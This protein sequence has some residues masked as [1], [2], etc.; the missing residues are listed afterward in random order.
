MPVPLAITESL[1][2]PSGPAVVQWRRNPRA[3]RITLRIDPRAGHVVVTLPMRA[4]RAAGMALLTQNAD[5]VS[6]R[7]AAL[8]VIVPFAPGGTVTIDGVAHTIAHTPGAR[9]G[10]WLE[11]GALHVSGNAEFLARRV[12][13]FLRAEARR[14]FCA[15]ALAKAEAAGLTVRRVTVKDTRTRWGS[16][17][18]QG[19]LMFCWRLLMAPPYVQDYVVG[20][21][22]AHLA[23]LNHGPSF[24]ALCDELSPHREQASAWLTKEGA[25]LLRAG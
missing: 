3:R 21:E 11:E 6:A 13:D 14:R 15:Q 16:C 7:L 18:G 10:V 8:P 20:H 23:H 25:G 5:W 1:A 22:V 17:S 4:A 19:V 12:C 9:G 2:L 24:W